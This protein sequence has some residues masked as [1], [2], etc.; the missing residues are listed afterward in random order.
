MDSVSWHRATFIS[1]GIIQALSFQKTMAHHNVN[2]V[3]LVSARRCWCHLDQ[4]TFEEIP[5]MSVLWVLVSWYRSRAE[6]HTPVTLQIPLA[7]ILIADEPLQAWSRMPVTMWS[8]SLW[9][10]LCIGPPL[11]NICLSPFHRSDSSTVRFSPSSSMKLFSLYLTQSKIMEFLRNTFKLRWQPGRS[12]S[13]CRDRR[14]WRFI[15]TSLPS[16]YWIHDLIARYPQKFQ[17]QGLHRFYA[18]EYW[19]GGSWRCPRRIRYRVGTC[20]SFLW[21]HARYPR[22]HVRV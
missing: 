2:Y 5:I 3:F 11:L 7:L 17:L 1:I 8:S 22:S 6:K 10:S 21:H 15:R 16:F 18:G 14:R 19:S 20:I 4:S 12:F 13:T 9:L